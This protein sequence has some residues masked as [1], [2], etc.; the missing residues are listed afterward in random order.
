MFENSTTQSEAT[1][2]C[3]F[4]RKCF[5]IHKQNFFPMLALSFQNIGVFIGFSWFGSVTMYAVLLLPEKLYEFDLKGIKV[6]FE[7]VSF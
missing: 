1:I 6:S 2:F 7:T 4:T 3:S 5:D